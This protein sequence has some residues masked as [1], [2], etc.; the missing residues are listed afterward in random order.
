MLWFIM[1]QMFS[2]LLQWVGLAEPS[3]QEKDL[4]IL[5]RR[6]LAIL[7]RKVD[8]PIRV[9]RAEK[10]NLAQLGAVVRQLSLPD[11]WRT[12][13][14]TL[15]HG[16]LATTR[17]TRGQLEAELRRA[18]DLHIRGEFGDDLSVYS[19]ATDWFKGELAVLPPAE[20]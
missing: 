6:Q 5:L 12:E 9:S 20:H 13:L 18:Q 1:I 17:A 7:Q 19:A 2:T 8:T 16:E 3:E 14:K 4:E 15:L 10:L 11:D